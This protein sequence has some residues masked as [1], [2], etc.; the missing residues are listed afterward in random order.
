[1]W[2]F[3][4]RLKLPRKPQMAAAP[5]EPAAAKATPGG[6][7]TNGKHPAP[8]DDLVEMTPPF[9]VVKRVRQDVHDQLP[10]VVTPD[11]IVID[12]DMPGGS[13]VIDDD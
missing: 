9:K 7:K 10:V 3:A 1:M 12:D 13:I 4:D 8:D 5:P 2:D 6:G 11:A